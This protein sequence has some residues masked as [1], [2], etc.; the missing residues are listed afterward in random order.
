MS[1]KGLQVGIVQFTPGRLSIGIHQLVYH[2]AYSNA[3]KKWKYLSIV[4]VVAVVVVVVVAV[5]VVVVILFPE[6]YSRKHSIC[7]TFLQ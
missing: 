6:E 7:T 3:I 5:V 4:V 1:A 2:L